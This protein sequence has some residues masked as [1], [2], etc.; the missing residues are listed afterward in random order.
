MGSERLMR[1]IAEDV[2]KAL[3]RMADD[4]I[5]K[6]ALRLKLAPT[7]V[8]AY[9]SAMIRAGKLQPRKRIATPDDIARIRRLATQGLSLVGIAERVGIST[10]QTWRLMRREGITL[11]GDVWSLTEL[12]RLFGV[13]RDTVRIWRAREWIAPTLIKGDEAKRG[14]A[15]RVSRSDLQRFVRERD[16]WPTYNP[17]LIQDDALRALALRVRELAGG[18]WVQLTELANRAGIVPTAVDKRL[19]NGWLAGWE[20]TRVGN[21]RFVWWPAKQLLPPYVERDRFG[22]RKRRQEAA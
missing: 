6:I 11:G 4:P 5:A 12:Q 16:A 15:Q 22:W 1:H 21:W 9:R 17:A 14:I 10:D 8:K 18:E 20:W 3:V 7:T 2:Q 19:S 13:G